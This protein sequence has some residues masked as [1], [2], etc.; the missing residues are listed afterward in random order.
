LE[1]FNYWLGTMH[2]LR[3]GAKLDCA[4]GKFLALMK[5]VGAEKDPQVRKQLA[6]Q[7]ALPAY[8]EILT[9]YTEAFGHLLDTA[10]TKGALATVMYW[11]HSFYHAALGNT[12]QALA[13]A[14]GEP[15]PPDSQLPTTYQGRT[16]L[17]APTIRSS[18]APGEVLQLQILVLAPESPRNVMLHYRQL[19]GGEYRTAAF[20]HVARGVYT[21]A[22]PPD[23]AIGDLEYYVEATVS[24]GKPLRW[25][26]TAPRINQT[27]VL[28]PETP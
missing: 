26:A 4:T 17:I 27:L 8:R 24:D 13:Q 22:F 3:A 6:R 10:N 5:T 20:R 2:Y 21:V 19:G 9:A 7:T 15:L 23:G 18:I 12:G 28:L 16:R 11:E 25:P 1:R 14:L